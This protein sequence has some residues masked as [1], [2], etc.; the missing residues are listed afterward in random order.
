MMD[1]IRPIRTEA[2]YNWALSEIETYFD[3]VP[4]MGTPEADRFDILAALIETY[5]AKVWPIEAP[6]PVEAIKATM[7]SKGLSQADLA[8]FLGSRSRASEIINRKRPLTLGMVQKLH[9]ELGLPAD[10]L[11]QPYHVE[12]A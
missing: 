9:S 11:I 8:R 3:T 6:D 10:V 2:D 1:N 4:D 5:E 7:E 12:A